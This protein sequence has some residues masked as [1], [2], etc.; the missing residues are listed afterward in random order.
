MRVLV[1]D[2][3]EFTRE[4]IIRILTDNFSISKIVRAGT[5]ES[6][7][8]EIQNTKFDLMILDVNLPG[9][10]G[11]ELLSTVRS[12]QPNVPVL[13]LSMVPV[14]Q[15]ARRVLQAGATGYMTKSEPAE[16]FLKAVKAVSQRLKYFSPEVQ[17]E[18]PELIDE[19]IS[20]PKHEKLSDREFDI[21]KRMSD[22]KSSKEIAAE[23][24][25][26]VNTVNSY[27]KRIMY[28]LHLKTNADIIK[29]AFKNRL[30]K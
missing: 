26:T 30:I 15:Y 9:K 20:K 17:Q 24:N 12:M 27:R 14:S 5:Y 3:H 8:E 13:V 18:I 21:L 22:G 29:Y 11:L 16:E 6:A 28:K 10:S 2:D 1:V 19:S 25:I 4:G 7:L 23:F